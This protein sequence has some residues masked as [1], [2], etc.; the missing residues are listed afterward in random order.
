[1]TAPN[2]AP[3][4]GDAVGDEDVR[5]ANREVRRDQQGVRLLRTRMGD[6]VLLGDIAWAIEKHGLTLDE[7][8]AAIS[9]HR[10][11]R[12]T[13]GADAGAVTDEESSHQR[14]HIADV[15]RLTG[16]DTLYDAG[17][18]LREWKRELQGMRAAVAEQGERRLPSIV[19]LSRSLAEAYTPR[20]SREVCISIRSRGVPARTLSR[21]FAAVLH[22]EFDDVHPD[23]EHA[24]NIKRHEAKLL[25][26]W[27]VQHRAASRL[28]I[29]C[30]AGA[31]RSV[32]VAAALQAGFARYERC[33]NQ[34]TY[35]LVRD[36]V[37]AMP[38]ARG[39]AGETGARTDGERLDW[40]AATSLR[41]GADVHV[42][43]LAQDQGHD[44]DE[45]V[46]ECGL[47][48]A[49]GP[50]IRAAIDAAMSTAA[51]PHAEGSA[52]GGADAGAGVGD[53]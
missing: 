16:A 14:E 42:I 36:A 48:E 12:A 38:G 43:Q 1:M 37:D 10:A 50:D 7:V 4:V 26:E 35:W 32:S 34:G 24:Q 25:V 21:D 44:A 28:V 39:G 13:A 3:G 40:L 27:V 41:T 15:L 11:T 33:V 52:L 19:V 20:D 18:V 2:A 45:V 51:A 5:P 22:I 30:D 53:A 29:H 8:T 6:D 31:S 47:D 23:T 9:E 17:N 49:R 46:I